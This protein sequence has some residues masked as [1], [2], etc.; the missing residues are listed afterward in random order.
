MEGVSKARTGRSQSLAPRRHVFFSEVTKTLVFGV[1]PF[2]DN[3]QCEER[4]RRTLCFS[5]IQL[6]GWRG[7]PLEKASYKG[8]Y[9][10]PWGFGK[11]LWGILLQKDIDRHNSQRVSHFLLLAQIM[12]EK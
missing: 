11:T 9:A 8:K 6:V 12:K 5:F 3:R 7:L 1:W 4:G 10:G 2:L